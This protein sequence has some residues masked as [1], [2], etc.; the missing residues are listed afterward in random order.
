[1][2]STEGGQVDPLEAFLSRNSTVGAVA[3]AWTWATVARSPEGY[4]GLPR[5]SP[6]KV[7]GAVAKLGGEAAKT[8]FL[9]P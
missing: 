9:I 2:P 6:L 1:M 8:Q 5:R 4:A 7:K 3:K